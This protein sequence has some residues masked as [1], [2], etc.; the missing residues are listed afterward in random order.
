MGSSNL[1]DISE[2]VLLLPQALSKSL[3]G[4][5]QSLVSLTD[6]GDVHDSGKGI[7]R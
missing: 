5:N 2:L 1:N 6:S 7:I 3:Q 4:W